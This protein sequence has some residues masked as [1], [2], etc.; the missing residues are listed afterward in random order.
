MLVESGAAVKHIGRTFAQMGRM[1]PPM[2]FSVT[3]QSRPVN[4]FQEV[5]PTP[6][7]QQGNQQQSSGQQ[8]AATLKPKE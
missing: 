6:T 2:T 4:Q 1:A 8:S 3:L 7:P 5:K